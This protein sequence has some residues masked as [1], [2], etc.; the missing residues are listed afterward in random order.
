VNGANAEHVRTVDR[1]TVFGFKALIK[2]TASMQ[3][4]QTKLNLFLRKKKFFPHPVKSSALR[5]NFRRFLAPILQ[6]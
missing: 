1:P 3:N 4:R 2:E 5:M 6:E